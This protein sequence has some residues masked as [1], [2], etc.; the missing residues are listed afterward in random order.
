M[1]LIAD[2]VW[3]NYDQTTGAFGGTSCAAPLWAGFMALVNQQAA[4]TGAKPAGFINPAIYAIATGTN[5]TNCFHDITTGNNFWSS[6]PSLFA[7]TNGYDL[8]TGLG[9]PAG[10]NLINALAGGGDPLGISPGA[11][12]ALSGPLGG[13]F[14]PDAGVFQL[15]NASAAALNWSL[16][17]TSA[18]LTAAFTSGTLAAHAAT[19]LSLALTAAAGTL[20]VGNYSAT[21]VFTNGTSHV[22][23]SFPF[24]LQIYQPLSVTPVKG[25]AAV[26]PVGGPFSS[27]AQTLIVT[28]LSGGA[29]NW[30]LINTSAW[31]TASPASGTLAGGGQ[32]NVT[33]GLSA[34]ASTLAAAVYGANLI[35]T[36]AS[37]VVAVVPFSVSVGQPILQNGGFETGNF[38]DWTQSG[39]TGSS[40]VTSGNANYVYSGTYGAQLGPVGS[41]GYLSQNL[42]TV[43]GQNYLLSFWLRNYSG[44]T[45]NQFQ[46][47]WNGTTIYYQSNITATVWTNLQFLVTAPSSATPLQFGFQNDPAYFGLDA[48]NV[49][50]LAPVAFKSTVKAANNFSLVW[51]TTAGVVYQVQYKTNLLQAG[52]INL[53]GALTATSSSLTM[54]DTN[55]FVAS[56]RRF[57]RLAVVP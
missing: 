37:G 56:P 39:N 7:A 40:V 52:W 24:A 36:N 15:T 10:Q 50:P 14:N 44:A 13:P 9:T 29:V 35:F 54:T 18:W 1:A 55:A 38:T 5:Y 23:Q 45:P 53:G 51:N 11:G 6:S 57:Y 46:V 48:I 3:V 2:S 43:A 31:L 20:A 12:F 16:V 21:I 42:T 26:G 17:N 41:L 47:Q 28:N 49:T 25:F 22:V 30:S 33:A 4:A 19:N 34:S 8:C 27:A 32:A